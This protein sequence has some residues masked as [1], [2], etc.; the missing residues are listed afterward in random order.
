MKRH[1]THLAAALLAASAL[2]LAS[3]HDGEGTADGVENTRRTVLVYMAAHNSLGARGTKKLSAAEAD[4]AEIM[5]GRK[6]IPD[7]CTLL[8]FIDDDRPPRLYRVTAKTDAPQLV[9]QWDGEVC[10][11]SPA[12][13]RDALRLAAE[14]APAEEYGLVLWSHATGWL[15]ATYTGYPADSTQQTAAPLF[16]GVDTGEGNAM[17]TNDGPQME[18]A[19]I[20]SAVSAAGMHCRYIFFDACLMQNIEVA[21][22]LRHVADYVVGAPVS[23]P[24]AGA[25]YTH[26]MGRGLFSSDPADIART[27]LSDVKDPLLVSHYSDFGVAVSCLRTD[28]LPALAAALREVLPASALAGKSS[29]DMDGVLCYQNYTAKYYYRPHNHDMWQA[30]GRLLT[31]DALG[32]VRD[33][34]DEAVA[35]SGATERFWT[36][37]SAADFQSVDVT[38]GNYRGVSMFVPQPVYTANA[39]Q[40]PY[41]DLNTR[42]RATEWY[43]DAGFAA[44]GW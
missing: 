26:Q 19:D 3:C 24:A 7:G 20:A 23:T 15:P 2:T 13:L 17:E 27:Y 6:N 31:G 8:F 33:A 22:A 11:T 38:A 10:S 43:T 5:A 40:C 32:R 35:Y 29:P 1:A 21:Y 14:K 34:L 25:Y 28:K 18:V 42:F 16:F 12:T 30:L 4:S 39:S 41:G 37:P 44:T 36:G 9:R